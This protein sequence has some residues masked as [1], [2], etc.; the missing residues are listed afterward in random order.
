VGSSL[1]IDGVTV[2]TT[3]LRGDMFGVNSELKMITADVTAN[4]SGEMTL[5][6]SPP[7][8]SSPA[9]DAPITISSPTAKFMLTAD[10]VPWDDSPGL[11]TDIN[12]SCIEDF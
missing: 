10:E 6:F 12:I 5:A 9:N 2:G 8:R 1:I 4:G 7:L 11:M 3:L